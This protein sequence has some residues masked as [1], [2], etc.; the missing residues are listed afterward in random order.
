MKLLQ[1]CIFGCLVALRYAKN[2]RCGKR[3]KEE[4]AIEDG[5]ELVFETQRRN[6]IEYRE[7]VRCSVMCV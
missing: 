3:T 5:D 2:V 1:L 7:F 4:V 6:E